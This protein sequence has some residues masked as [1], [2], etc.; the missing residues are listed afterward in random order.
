GKGKHSKRVKITSVTPSPQN[1]DVLFYGVD[2]KEGVGAWSSLCTDAQ[3]NDTD[4]ILIGNL[5]DPASAARV[6][7]GVQGA[8]TFACRGAALAKCV[9]WGYR[10]WGEA[11]GAS[12][13][14]F[15]QTCTRLVRADY[16]GDGISHTVDGTGIH[17]LDEIGVQDLDPDVTFVIEA[18]W[19]PSGALCLNA[20]NTRI[21]DVQIECELPA[22]GAPFESG[23]IIQSG[24]ITAP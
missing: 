7:D 5:W 2:L 18:E 15:H 3:G 4:A 23:G 9:E 6:G 24:K 10:P 1:P 11:G 12:L 21:A 22:C 13:E 14:D 16:C 8:V 17:V 19:G 20:A